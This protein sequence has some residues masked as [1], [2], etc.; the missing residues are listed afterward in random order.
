M[1]RWQAAIATENPRLM[2]LLV[3]LLK[4]LDISFIMCVPED[5]RS[6]DAKIA[7]TSSTEVE[8]AETS[9]PIVVEEGFEPSLLTIR[10][11]AR[12]H[13]VDSPEY[14][15]IGVDPGMMS[16]VALVAEG[17]PL[18]QTSQGSPSATADAVL[19][20]T[21]YASEIFP[22]STAMVRVGAGSRLFSVLTLRE[23]ARL[24]DPSDIEIVNEERTTVSS[25]PGANESSAIIIA[26]RQG[27]TL[28]QSDFQLEPKIGYIKSLKTLTR[29]LSRKRSTIPTEK[30][31]QVILG[32]RNLSSILEELSSA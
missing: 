6:C 13:D 26:G 20:L 3:E 11:L 24:I 4:S 28:I 32:E 30:A 10:L 16:G 1:E 8:K 14:V 17:Q 19:L 21:H 5:R 7:I 25:G 2:Y 15:F 12:L 27:R 9:D 29:R 23:I 31:R 22:D 18:Y